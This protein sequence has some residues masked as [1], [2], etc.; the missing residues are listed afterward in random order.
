MSISTVYT[1]HV[2]LNSHGSSDFVDCNRACLRRILDHRHAVGYTFVEGTGHYLGE[3]E[4]TILVSV[5]YNDPRNFEFDAAYV[6]QTAVLIKE[7][8][9]QEAVWITRRSVDL[10]IV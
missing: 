10:E 7:A 9:E 1:I 6:K 4:P 8:L 2:G 5:A 3:T